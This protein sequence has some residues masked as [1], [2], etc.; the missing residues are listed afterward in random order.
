VTPRRRRGEWTD[1]RIEAPIEVP[2]KR[3]WS[4]WIEAEREVE[5]WEEQRTHKRNKVL[6]VSLLLRVHR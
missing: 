5:R 2:R 1:R 3:R 6:S 4:T